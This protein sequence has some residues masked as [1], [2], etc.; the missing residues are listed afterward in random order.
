MKEGHRM[1][2]PLRVLLWLLGLALLV[3]IALLANVMIREARVCREPE[4]AG[5]YDAII[6]LGAQVLPDGTPNVQLS[7]RLD[8]AVKA[9]QLHRVPVVVCGA[10]GADEPRPEAEAMREYLVQRGVSGDMILEDPDSFNTEQNIRNAAKLL[11]DREG[12]HR[13]LLIS[14]DYHVPRAMAL[15][16]DQGFEATG[17]GA[18][19]LAEYWLKNHAREALAWVKYWLNKY[20]HLSL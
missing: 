6:V 1:A 4:N 11:A 9:W 7:L 5:E 15:A 16:A 2:W 19:C 12:I 17:L 3:F 10:Q 20:L 18:P 13:V 8:A 14:S